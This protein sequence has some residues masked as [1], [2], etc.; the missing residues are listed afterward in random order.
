MLFS[1]RATFESVAAHPKWL[2]V[3]LV[4]LVIGTLA[5]GAFMFSPVGSQAMKDQMVQQAE[6]QIAAQG[7]NPADAV[8]RIE[9]F[10]PIF[11][12]A[13]VAASPVIGLLFVMIIAGVLYGVFGAIL[14]GGGTF[15]QALAVV[16]HAGIVYQ[17]GALITLTLNY[18][19][20]NM[21]SATTLGV[22]A[23]MLA[24]DS[25]VFKL[26]NAI[27][28]VT[29]WYMVILAMGMAV[30]YR[31]KTAMVAVSFFSLY[32]IIAVIRAVFTRGA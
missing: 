29:I 8:G 3:F 10:F 5:F 19:R 22:F 23:P 4:T 9:A 24:E 32:L 25:F 1:P 21:T 7:G 27:D 20:A 2:D 18:L 11:R 15:K 17:I 16:V 13:I 26:L 6:K 28:L 30:L 31:R 12:I 14:G